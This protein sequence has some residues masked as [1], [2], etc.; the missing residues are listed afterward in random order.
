M[1]GGRTGATAP[2]PDPFSAV[3]DAPP[4]PDPRMATSIA[5]LR[6]AFSDSVGVSSDTVEDRFRRGNDGRCG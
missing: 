1:G 2:A 6:A 4:G 3:L 5:R